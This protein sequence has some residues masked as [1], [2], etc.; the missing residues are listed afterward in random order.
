MRRL[1]GRVAL[2]S[3]AAQDMGKAVALRL[4]EEGATIVAVD[5]NE[6]PCNFSRVSP[7]TRSRLAAG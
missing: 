7:R 1:E 5:I 6:V 4:G 2:V 3:G